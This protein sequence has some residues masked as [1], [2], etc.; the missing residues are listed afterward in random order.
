MR[1]SAALTLLA[2]LLLCSPS[3][4]VRASEPE[5]PASAPPTPAAVA[6]VKPSE[7]EAPPSLQPDLTELDATGSY[8]SAW[9][10]HRARWDPA[11]WS[12]VDA[13][14]VDARTVG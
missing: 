14:A 3:L 10:G 4:S 13:L 12:A 5:A 1:H 6:T 9:F 7:P 2:A 8:D 11:L